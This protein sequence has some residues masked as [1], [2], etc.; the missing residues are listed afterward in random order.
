MTRCYIT[1]I[2]F[3]EKLFNYKFLTMKKHLPLFIKH[4]LLIC[5]SLLSLGCGTQKKL[6]PLPA[7]A[8]ILAFGDSLTVGVGTS[9]EYSYPSI[10]SKLSGFKVIH[11]GI[12]GETTG[13]GLKRLP[14]VLK[15]HKPHL[16][17]LMEGGNDILRDIHYEK[18][19][20]N[21]K[22]MIELIKQNQSQII[23]IGI[24]EK[25]LFSDS[26]PFYDKLANQYSLV[27]QNSI[28]G[29][30]QRNREYKSDYIHFNKIGYRKLAESIHK[31][32]KTSEAIQ[33]S[34]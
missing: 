4:I 8:T 21:L 10:L 29:E 5:L 2:L 13:Q 30:L 12:S 9:K 1:T 32:L 27:F 26:A 19:E 16:V 18:I 23:L 3:E 34:Y 15:T 28:I 31:L 6:S 11:S 20:E 14:H 25:K 22:K 33:S 7:N 24:P 17:I